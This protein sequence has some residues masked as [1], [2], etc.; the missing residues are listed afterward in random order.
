MREDQ[1]FSLI[2]GEPISTDWTF[3][4]EV[5]RNQQFFHY[6]YVVVTKMLK[7]SSIGVEVKV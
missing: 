4:G 5:T 2:A 6:T 3:N 7:I 1:G